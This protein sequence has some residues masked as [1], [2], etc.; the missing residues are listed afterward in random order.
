MKA[1]HN[2]AEEKLFNKLFLINNMNSEF[3]PFKETS[4]LMLG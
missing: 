3:D 2:C 4:Y 1:F